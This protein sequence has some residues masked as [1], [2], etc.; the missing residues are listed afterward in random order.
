MPQ[1]KQTRHIVKKAP[2]KFKRFQSDL[3]MRVKESWRKP[4]GIDNRVRRRYKGSRHMPVVGY[5][6][7]SKTKHMLQNG[8]RAFKINSAKDLDLLL[9]HNNTYAAVIATGVNAA[10]RKKIVERALQLDIKVMNGH[11]RLRTQENE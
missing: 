10:N 6:S 5:G 11:A 7:D 1:A 3:F 4:R 2:S 9:M 8:F